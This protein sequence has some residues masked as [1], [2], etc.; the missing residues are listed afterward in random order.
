[1]DCIVIV[2]ADLS[3]FLGLKRFKDTRIQWLQQDLKPWFPYQEP[4][5]ATKAP[6]SLRS[7][8]LSRVPISKH[9]PAGSMTTRERIRR[10]ASN[11][12][13]TAPFF[14]KEG[15]TNRPNEEQ[16]ISRMALLSS[17]LLKP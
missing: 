9:L 15:A 7:L 11:S 10:M 13:K 3:A 4:Y 2:R 17:G 14:G 5:Y 12:P 8:F 1:M 16:I 6:S